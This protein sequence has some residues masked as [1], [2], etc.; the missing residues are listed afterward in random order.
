MTLLR[1]PAAIAGLAVS[2]VVM[3]LSV[4]IAAFVRDNTVAVV[5][6]VLLAQAAGCVF[7]PI[8]VGYV[9]EVLREKEA[10]GAA[11]RVFG[12]L[13]DA[14][15]A[16]I[17][18]DR[19]E[20]DSPDNAL[21]QLRSAFLTHR[22]GDV[23]LVGVS[24]RVFFNPAGPFYQNIAAIAKAGES[25]P[26]IRIRALMLHREAAEIA[27][28]AAIETPNMEPPLIVGA[29]SSSLANLIHL[30]SEFPSASIECGLYGSAPYCT[31][32]LFPKLCFF[33]PNILCRT[34]P[35]RLP[36]VVFRSGSHGYRVLSDYFDH[37]W[38]RRTPCPG[39]NADD[40]SAEVAG[41]ACEET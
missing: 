21:D 24:L 15:I 16:R 2:F 6:A 5:I 31:A 37:L 22:A 26:N 35:V 18:K 8:I 20:S 9:Y 4:M 39:G 11:W 28:R 25:N 23:R 27:H 10:A 38:D 32:V 29:I 34:A 40:P 36:L 12:E 7:F 33:S 19:E 41:A 3:C 17:Y 13:A 1:Q 30:R 14:G